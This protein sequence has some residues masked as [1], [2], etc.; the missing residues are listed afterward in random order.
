MVRKDPNNL[1]V[2]ISVRF[3]P[4]E[5]KKLQAIADAQHERK[6]GS[7]LR[8]ICLQYGLEHYKK[9]RRVGTSATVALLALLGSIGVPQP[10]TARFFNPFA[11]APIVQKEERISRTSIDESGTRRSPRRRK[12]PSGFSPILHFSPPH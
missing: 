8:R 7:L 1:T 2:R 9:R 3:T 4:K 6:I 12:T 5:I 11:N 10:T